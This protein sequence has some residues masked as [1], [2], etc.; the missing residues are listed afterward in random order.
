MQ[1]AV[2]DIALLHGELVGPT[3]EEG[4]TAP[5]QAFPTGNDFDPTFG[6]G[7]IDFIT[8]ELPGCA[9]IPSTFNVSFDKLRRVFFSLNDEKSYPEYLKRRHV[10]K[11]WEIPYHREI[12]NKRASK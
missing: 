3:L 8:G 1:H 4:G 2:Q 12:L 11:N 6:F 5:I 7:E 10:L 9:L